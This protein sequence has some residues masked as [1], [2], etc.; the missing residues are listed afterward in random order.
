MIDIT[1]AEAGGCNAARARGQLT[2]TLVNSTSTMQFKFALLAA[3]FL[4]L[5]SVHGVYNITVDN[6]DTSIIYNGFWG[7]I[8]L[9]GYDY[10]GTQNLVDLGDNLDKPGAD[11][12][13]TFIF[14]GRFY[15]TYC[16]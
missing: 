16:S 13:A 1:H 14:T 10:G 7:V 11:S 4:S 8:T 6:T 2:S 5:S 3:L 9:G 12:N 15:L